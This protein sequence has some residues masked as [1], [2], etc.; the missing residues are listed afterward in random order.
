M[1]IATARRPPPSRARSRSTL[2]IR[3]RARRLPDPF[4][5]LLRRDHPLRIGLVDSERP[6]FRPPQRRAVPAERLGDRPDIGSRADPQVE[7]DNAVAIG[8]D[9]E[10]VHP[11]APQ[12][13]LDA[14]AA[15]VQ[16]VGPLAADL[17]RRGSR[18]RQLDLA[19]EAREPPLELLLVRRLQA[20]DDLALAVAGRRARREVDLRDVALVEPDEA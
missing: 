20:L 2:T 16:P 17:D 18:D 11:G 6:D 1:P 3:A 4:E 15:P 9:V 14:I 5:R 13:H 8:D 7:P 12:R 10:R 19:A